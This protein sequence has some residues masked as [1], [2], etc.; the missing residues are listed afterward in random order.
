MKEKIICLCG[1]EESIK[2]VKEISPNIKNIKYEYYPVPADYLP[3][4]NA[5]YMIPKENMELSFVKN[6]I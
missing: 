1:T 2:K 4:P 3:N 6:E 5:I